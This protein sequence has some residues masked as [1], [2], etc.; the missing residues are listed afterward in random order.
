MIAVLSPPKTQEQIIDRLL[1]TV[2]PSR[3]SC[4]SKCRLQFWFRYVVKIEK[5]PT[6][7]LHVGTSIHAVLKQWNKARWQKEKL[8]LKQLYD[9]LIEAWKEQPKG[10]KWEGE[11]ANQQ[12]AAWALLDTYA[13]QTPIPA[14]ERPEAVEVEAEAELEPGL[15]ILRGVLDLVRANKVIVDFKTSSKSPNPELVIHTTEIQLTSYA[16]LYR[17][18]TGERENGLE[19]HHLVKGKNPKLVV[20]S[21]PPITGQQETRLLRTIQSYA[22]GLENRDIIPSPG[23]HCTSCEF[24]NQCR[25]WC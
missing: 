24:F 5:P 11:E 20:T 23:I 16:V 19:L 21:A 17:T 9:L 2:S 13:R 6:A 3:L 15:P 4:W 12:K 18:A 7:A 25:L 10:I 1:Q 14:D 22:N 8:T